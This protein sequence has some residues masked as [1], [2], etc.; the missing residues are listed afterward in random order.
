[1]SRSMT[2]HKLKGREEQALALQESPSPAATRAAPQVS[3]RKPAV[4]RCNSSWT[5]I[6]DSSIGR[7]AV[8]VHRTTSK[9]VRPNRSEARPSTAR[10]CTKKVVMNRKR[11]KASWGLSEAKASSQPKEAGVLSTPCSKCFQ[12]NEGIDATSRFDDED[13]FLVEST[14][15]GD[16]EEIEEVL[17]QVPRR[18]NASP[19]AFDT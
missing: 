12:Q 10:Q 8:L 6:R 1:M 9:V 2:F 5:A 4:T 19:A 18:K 14:Q 3:R 17:I 7:S 11:A 15:V 16:D 13:N